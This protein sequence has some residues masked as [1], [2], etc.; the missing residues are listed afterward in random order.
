LHGESGQENGRLEPC[1]TF[2]KVCLFIKLKAALKNGVWINAA[3]SDCKNELFHDGD[4][5]LSNEIAY[6][7]GTSKKVNC[8]TP[9]KG[10][11]G[12]WEAEGWDLGGRPPV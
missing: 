8:F 12:P 7:L 9:K 5:I 11:P 10:R 2:C 4:L 1:E 3:S 6:T